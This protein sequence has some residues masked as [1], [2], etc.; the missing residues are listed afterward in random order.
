MKDDTNTFFYCLLFFGLL[1]DLLCCLIIST[2]ELLFLLLL[3]YWSSRHKE[4]MIAT[5]YDFGKEENRNKQKENSFTSKH[6]FKFFIFD[7]KI[8]LFCGEERCVI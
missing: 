7:N 2:F 1:N 6:S 4:E 8:I 5:D 3:F